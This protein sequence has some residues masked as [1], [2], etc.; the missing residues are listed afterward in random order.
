M[1]VKKKSPERKAMDS[2]WGFLSL[3]AHLTESPMTR[4]CKQIVSFFPAGVG[5]Q[6]VFD[7]LC[8]ELIEGQKE[9][10]EFNLIENSYDPKTEHYYDWMELL[11]YYGAPK[12]RKYLYEVYG[13][14]AYEPVFDDVIGRFERRWFDI[15]KHMKETIYALE[16]MI[17]KRSADAVDDYLKN[18]YY[19]MKEAQVYFSNI[20]PIEL[21]K[22]LMNVDYI[23]GRS[24]TWDMDPYIV[25]MDND[26]KLGIMVKHDYDHMMVNRN[27]IL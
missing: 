20:G 7:I 12:T 21:G 13:N 6:D 9:D 5:T 14:D 23:S 22:R 1:Y 11:V 2:Y 8:L 19:A 26:A 10:A 27:G 15:I 3:L 24:L 18:K 16:N 25:Q 4:I 17:T